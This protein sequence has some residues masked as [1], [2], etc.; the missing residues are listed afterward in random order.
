YGLEGWAFQIATLLAGRLSDT[1]L[2]AHVIALNLASAAFMLPLGLSIGA[3]TRVGNLVGAGLHA[4]ARRPAVLAMAMGGGLM[5]VSA[6]L[7]LLLR[8]QLPRMFTPD[9]AAIATAASIRP[10]AAAFALFD[11]TQAV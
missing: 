2:A 10:I 4:A 6:I 7:F 5:R 1:A 11:G 9:P 3:S 8:E